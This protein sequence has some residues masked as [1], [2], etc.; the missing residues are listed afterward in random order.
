MLCRD[1]LLQT[2]FAAA[3]IALLR[4]SDLTAPV[5]VSLYHAVTAVL[6]ALR[7]A[8]LDMLCAPIALQ[9]LCAHLQS[10]DAD[11]RAGA[12]HFVAHLAVFSMLTSNSLV[13]VS[14]IFRTDQ[15]KDT[16]VKAAGFVS[17]LT[18]IAKNDR[19]PAA[20]NARLALKLIGQPVPL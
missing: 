18:R 4:V 12:T 11:I 5:I 13:N 2:D 10:N 6:A 19:S 8:S 3:V 1:H 9:Q 7:H 17:A 14:L 20:R 15:I 16:L